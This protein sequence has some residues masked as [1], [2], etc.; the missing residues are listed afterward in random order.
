MNRM[1]EQVG[2]VVVITVNYRQN[3]CTL[4]CIQSLLSLDYGNFQIILVDNGPVPEDSEKLQSELSEE[5]IYERLDENRGYTGGINHGLTKARL[6]DPAYIII[7]NNDTI[8]DKDALK[9]LVFTSRSYNDRCIV[10]GKAYHYDDPNRIQY[11]G[12]FASNIKMLKFYRIGSDEEDEGQY[13]EIGERDLLDDIFWLIPAGVLA[14]TGFYNN[15]FWFNGESAD[16]ALRAVKL[17]YKLI[18]T[19]NAKIWHKG[20]ISAGGRKDNPKL[21][22]WQIQSTLIFRF[23]HLSPLRFAGF[24]LILL[25]SIPWGYL[26]SFR[27]SSESRKSRR[28]ELLAKLLAVNYFTRWVFTKHANMGENPFN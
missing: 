18:Y 12:H 19:P 3:E 6:L 21:T 8:I 4:E 13:D 27:L 5:V 2:K 17:G 26:K 25:S 20:S 7:L 23:L 10:T 14:K 15:Y 16:Y 22:Y 1:E 28:K 11:I 9:E 24:Y